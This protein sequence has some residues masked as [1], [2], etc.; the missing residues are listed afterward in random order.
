M[1]E[2]GLHLVSHCT[3]QHGFQLHPVKR[4]PDSKALSG[5][6]FTRP[7]RP[8]EWNGTK[9]NGT[10]LGRRRPKLKKG[11]FYYADR[12]PA[13]DFLGPKGHKSQKRPSRNAARN[14]TYAPAI[15]LK[16]IIGNPPVKRFPPCPAGVAGIVGTE[17]AGTVV[18]EVHLGVGS[19]T[20]PV[21][22]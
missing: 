6:R 5:F 15:I 16:P 1:R 7:G 13:N 19:G 3:H 14:N 8:A 17:G 21:K 18:V 2:A 12:F 22:V 9:W 20:F 10:G 11:C 4:N